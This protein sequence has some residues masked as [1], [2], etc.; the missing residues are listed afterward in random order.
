MGWHFG[1]IGIL[2]PTL[3]LLA[4]L[5]INCPARDPAHKKGPAG[6]KAQPAGPKFPTWEDRRVVEVQ[7]DNNP[8]LPQVAH[9]VKSTKTSL[10]SP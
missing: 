8:I 6:V 2:L 3:D 9:S 7:S 1:Y 4:S 5:T 10:K